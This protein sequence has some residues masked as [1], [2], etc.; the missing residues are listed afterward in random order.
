MLLADYSTGTA[1]I[2]SYLYTHPAG[3]PNYASDNYFADV[4]GDDLPEVVFARITGNN[5]AQFQVMVSK[6]LKNE[7]NPP[8]D[9][10]FYN[11]PITA[12]GW[13]TVRW[14]QICSEVVGGFWK[15]VQG[16][17][18]VRVN[19]V[20][21]GNPTTD[22]WSTATNT[23]QV[24]TYFGPAGLG[25]IPATPQELGGFSGGTA[26]G[27]INAINAGSFMLQHRDHGSYDGWG[28]PAFNSTS[29]SSLTNVNNKLPFIFSI[30]CQTGA[31]HNTSEC[32]AEKFHRWTYGGQNSGALGLIAAT[33]VSYSF[34]NDVYVWGLFDNLWTNFMPGY[35][36]NPASRD[37]LPAFGNAAGKYFL[38]Q[39]GWPYNT[40]DK[41]VTYRL[42][43]H[44]GD[45]FMTVYTEVP[46]N[47]NVTHNAA[48]I[49][50]IS[51][52]NVT[53]NA[54]SFIALTVNGEIIAT[55]NGTGSPVSMTIE[56]QIPGNDMIVTVTKQNYFRYSS[57]V[58]IIPPTGPYVAYENHTI[59]DAS[60]NNNGLADFGE[61]ILLKHDTQ[62][63]RKC[64]CQ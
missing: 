34:V 42:F 23:S 51:S 27:V 31:F 56:P 44:H 18:P 17:N 6:F 61:A 37:V 64:Y 49:G 50:G 57:T 43:H 20:Y 54:G 13:Q 1:G 48:L 30:N 45:A 11:K 39:S 22:A 21:E 3:Y 7:R 8:T 2:T 58:T 24:L 41:Q 10:L 25:Y 12:L 5:N 36:T 46:Q 33:E 53:A 47:L 9:P 4:T 38:Y 15:N 29:I 52:F 19:A 55:A 40:G 26:Q 32:F 14:F 16:K 59:S 35:G 60:G 63:S 28:E 62:K